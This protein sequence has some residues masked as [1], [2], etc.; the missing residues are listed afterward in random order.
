MNNELEQLIAS[1]ESGSVEFK[2]SFGKEAIETIA[3]FANGN[4]GV[5]CVGVSDNGA[6]KGV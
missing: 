5:L 2:E 3:A 4:G 1:G 6:I